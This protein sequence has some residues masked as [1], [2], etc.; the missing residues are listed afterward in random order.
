MTSHF[1]GRSTNLYEI[2]AF[3]SF[4]LLSDVKKQSHFFYSRVS[5]DHHKAHPLS[6]T[7]TL[8]EERKKRWWRWR[9]LSLFHFVQKAAGNG[10]RESLWINEMNGRSLLALFPGC[11][12]T[13]DEY[14]TWELDLKPSSRR[15][16]LISSME[17]ASF[18]S[19]LVF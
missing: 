6:L 7:K 10:K 3:V 9:W 15:E 5:A 17:D 2:K 8:L 18:P 1:A 12:F 11:E 13:M 14:W 19:F 16:F 4:F